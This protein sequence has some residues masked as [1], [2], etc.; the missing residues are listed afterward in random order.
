MVG[1]KNGHIRKKSHPKM[2]NPRDIVGERTKKKKKK[3]RKRKRS[4][5]E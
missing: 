5:Q 1:L 4:E 3:K 2:V